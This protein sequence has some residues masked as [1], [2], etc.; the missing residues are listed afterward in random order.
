M[1]GVTC[2]HRKE[3]IHFFST[4]YQSHSRSVYI[5]LSTTLVPNILDTDIGPR[6]WSDHMGIECSFGAQNTQ[7]TRPNC[8]LNTNLLYL[9]PIH[10]EM[11]Q[12]IKTYFENNKACSV[13]PH[14]IW[15]AMKSVVRDKAI[16]ITASYKKEKQKHRLYQTIG[17]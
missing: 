1:H 6:V 16:A 14:M 2:T 12:E 9:E 8:R 5:F 3:T 7:K 4:Q 17:N 10:T 15:D 13:Y 11:E